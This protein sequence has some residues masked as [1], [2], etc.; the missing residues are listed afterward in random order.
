MVKN[1]IIN[2]KIPLRI[3]DELCMTTSKVAQKSDTRKNDLRKMVH[4]NISFRRTVIFSPR[5]N[6]YTIFLF[7]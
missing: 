7:Q 6:K 3:N 1:A 2:V 5:D 4:E